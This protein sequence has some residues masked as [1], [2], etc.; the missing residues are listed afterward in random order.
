MRLLRCTTHV[1][2]LVASLTAFT[3]GRVWKESVRLDIRSSSGA[4]VDVRVLTRGLVI[5]PPGRTQGPL[6]TRVD[7]TI[8]TPAVI[9]LLGVGDADVQAVDPA[10]ML[11][12]EVTQLRQ[13]APSPQRLTGH[14][15]RV[16]HANYADPYRVTTVPR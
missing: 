6:P 9:T 4:E 10:A 2:L 15:F 7:T 13:N 3:P 11:V 12:V 14:G 1:V 8:T 16:E 5:L